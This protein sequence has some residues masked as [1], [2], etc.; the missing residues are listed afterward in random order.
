MASLLK[1][2][3]KTVMKRMK[4]QS[5]VNIQKRRKQIILAQ[6][7]HLLVFKA[8]TRDRGVH[9]LVIRDRQR[10]MYLISVIKALYAVPIEP[11]E[12]ERPICRKT[13]IH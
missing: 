10:I 13:S 2:N 4:I 1:H 6:K 11:S 7:A 8:I 12:K 3:P 9:N 5:E